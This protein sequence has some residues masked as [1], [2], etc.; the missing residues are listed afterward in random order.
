MRKYE[1]QEFGD[2]KVIIADKN[3]QRYLM[4]REF[5]LNPGIAEGYFHK[6]KPTTPEEVDAA[7]DRLIN[8]V[9]IKRRNG[10]L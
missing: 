7:V 3:E 5:V 2:E 6:M 8:F 10:E 1:F 4:L 9:E